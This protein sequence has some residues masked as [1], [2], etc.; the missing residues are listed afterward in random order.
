[1]IQTQWELVP[2]VHITFHGFEKADDLV[3]N[4]EKTRTVKLNFTDGW[5]KQKND[6]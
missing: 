1:M 2:K 3:Q 4:K 5:T 6:G